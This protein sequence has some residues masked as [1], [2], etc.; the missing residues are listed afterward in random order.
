MVNIRYGADV[1]GVRA[2]AY[3]R[4]RP[5][6]LGRRE[7]HASIAAVPPGESDLDGHRLGK[8]APSR[9]SPECLCEACARRIHPRRIAVCR[10]RL[11]GPG[12]AA[13]DPAQPAGDRGRVPGLWRRSAA[14]RCQ[15]RPLRRVGSPTTRTTGRR[16][17][18][19]S[20]FRSP[21][22]SPRIRR[23]ATPSWDRISWMPPGFR[24]STIPGPAGRR[25][26]A[27]CSRCTGSPSRSRCPLDWNGDGV[28][29]EGRLVRAEW[30]MTAMSFLGGRTVRI[31]V[32]VPLAGSRE[33]VSHP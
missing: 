21:A 29:A 16:A 7:G 31:R 28:V 3:G 27:A 23:C 11:P 4:D 10:A 6:T 9:G 32:T 2:T 13:P 30:G 1:P 26:S 8:G 25:A 18:W 24:S 5:A 14:D 12:R 17:R 22:W 33:Q 20:T 19:S 15:L